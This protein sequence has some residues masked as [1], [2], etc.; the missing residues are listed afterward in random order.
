MKKFSFLIF[1]ARDGAARLPVSILTH[2]DVSHTCLYARWA[3][4]PRV[5]AMMPESVAARG[6]DI[7]CMGNTYH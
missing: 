6:A 5:K 7:L 3:T 2:G 4:R 1:Q